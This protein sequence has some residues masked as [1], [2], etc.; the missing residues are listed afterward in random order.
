MA[1]SRWQWQQGLGW[2]EE[3]GSRGLQLN[4]WL[5][6]GVGIGVCRKKYLGQCSWS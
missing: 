4:K 6:C 2:A 1:T 5:G 3:R